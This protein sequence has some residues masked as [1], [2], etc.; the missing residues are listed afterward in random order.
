MKKIKIII[1]LLLLYAAGTE[2]IFAS[3]ELSTYWSPGI[4]IGVLL[5]IVAAAFL[6]GNR[7]S[8]ERFD[9]KSQSTT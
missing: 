8:P 1:A 9:I 3:H 7:M 2:Y 4:L 5:M 6:I